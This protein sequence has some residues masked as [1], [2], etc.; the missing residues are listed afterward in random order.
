M[1]RQLVPLVQLLVVVALFVDRSASAQAVPGPTAQ[2][3]PQTTGAQPTAVQVSAVPTTP[4]RVDGRL[5]EEVYATATPIR[6]FIQTEPSQGSPA[7]ERTEAWVLFDADNLYVAGRCFDGSPERWVL[8]EMRRDIPTIANSESFGV[9]FDTFLDRRN[10]F[11]FEVNALGG[12]LDAQIANEAFPP[13]I[14]W[15]PVWNARVG[16]FDGGWSFEMVI[17]FR[18][19][20]YGPGEQQ[21]WG[22]NMRRVVGWKNEESHIVRVPRALG[23]RRGLMQVSLSAPLTGLQVPPGSRK[24]EV[25]PYAISSLTTDRVRRPSVS[26]D[27]AGKAGLD[28]K[29]GVTQNLT[30]DFTVNTDFAQVE[31]DTQQVNLTRFNL[32]FPERRTFFIEGQGIFTFGS[33]AGANTGAADVPRLFFS[34]QI[35][36]SR[37]QTVP[38]EGGARLTGK[39]GRT[40]LGFINIQTDD[41]VAAGALATN[42]TALRVRRDILRRSSIGVLYTGRSHSLRGPEGNHL[43]GADGTLSFG[44]NLNVN[45]YLARTRTPGLVGNALSYRGE[46]NYEGDRYGLRVERLVIDEA[47]N[48][49]VG[50]VRRP[51]MRKTTGTARFSPRPRRNR[52]VRRWLMEGTG[53]LVANHTGRR[54][55]QEWIGT[56]G[57]DF[58]N[59]D[60]VRALVTFNDEFVPRPFSISP[61]VVVPVDEYRFVTGTLRYTMGTQRRRLAGTVALDV[62]TFYA[63][64][65]TTLGFS[66]GRLQVSR[67]LAV[68]PGVSVNRV[69]LPF[70]AFTATVLQGRAIYTMSPRLFVTGIVQSN[71]TSHLVSTNLRLRWE[72]TPG[73]ELFVVYTDEGDSSVRGYPSVLNRAVVVKLS[74]LIRF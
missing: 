67:R 58:Q 3:V 73:S 50:F 1:P 20:R 59:S 65:K 43:F 46:F 30:A 14:D 11:L 15:N 29:Y 72:Y 2:P 45:A 63:G 55:T 40:N 27:L 18:S 35:G 39:V 34:R 56:A 12:F 13:N 53:T 19:L 57:V 5:D 10:G 51:D 71:S 70:G 60:Q 6:D 8:N 33:G 22:V 66:G 36:L 31:V 44:T 47:F 64:T 38:I 62:G 28:L 49:E 4:I 52:V 25:K 23:L 48:P 61:G 26:N 21:T 68:E 7:T 54:E 37:G 74:P 69:D 24:I 41:S 17:P 16:R 9:S 42:F 32:L